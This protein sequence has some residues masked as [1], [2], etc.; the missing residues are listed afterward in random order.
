MN[1]KD[2]KLPAKSGAEQDLERCIR[3]VSADPEISEIWLYGSCAQGITSPESDV[4]LLIVKSQ[5]SA[6][7]PRMGLDIARR[8]SRLRLNLPIEA[9]VVTRDLFVQRMKKPF[10]IYQDL[11]RHGKLLYARQS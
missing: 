5:S 1:T 2:I 7:S 11:S 4:D 10:G 3:E 6:S 9:A 8:I